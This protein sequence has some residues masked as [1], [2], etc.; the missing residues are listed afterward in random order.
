MTK[1]YWGIYDRDQ[2]IDVVTDQVYRI[3]RIDW[4]N[5]MTYFPGK[6]LTQCRN[7]YRNYSKVCGDF[8]EIDSVSLQF[9]KEQ[10]SKRPIQWSYLKKLMPSIPMHRIIDQVKQLHNEEYKLVDD[11][12]NLLE[13]LELDWW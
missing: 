5:I 6:T 10:C 7:A 11:V 8:C 13:R 2:L 4:I 9:I 1:S 12:L 3:G